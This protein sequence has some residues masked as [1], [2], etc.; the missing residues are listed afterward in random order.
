MKAD[1]K[2]LESCGCCEGIDTL[3]PESIQNPPGLSAIAYRVGTHSSFKET[4]KAKLAGDAA[5]SRLATRDDDD[6]TIALLDAWA[7]VAD[8]LTFY[9]ERIANEGYLRTAAERRSVLELARSLGYELKPGV[10]ASTYLAFELETAP[11]S[12]GFATIDVGTKVQSLPGPGEKPQTFET[13]EKIEARSALNALKPKLT[14]LRFPARGDQSLYLA[15]ISTNLKPGDPLLIVGQERETNEH[16]PQWELRRVAGVEPDAQANRTLIRLDK[17]LS[18]IPSVEPSEKGPRVCALRTRAALFG[19]NAQ[20]WK[21][22]PAALRDNTDA[23]YKDRENDWADHPFS[24][25]TTTI[26]LDAVYTQVV[27]NSWIVLASPTHEELYRVTGVGEETKA[28]FNITGKTTRLEIS[29]EN[30]DEFSARNATVYAQSEEL[31]MAEAP[32]VKPVSG[33]EIVLD[34]VVEGLERGQQLLVTGR[35]VRAPLRRAPTLEA[36]EGGTRTE[37]GSSLKGIPIPDLTG[38]R[39]LP[40]VVD[41]K[42]TTEVVE[43]REA[44]PEGDRY[45]TL[46]LAEPLR[47]AYD[48]PSV[49]IHGNVAAATH[50]ETRREVL[51]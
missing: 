17:R 14:R 5:L 16:S 21:A 27:L 30:I 50:G 15:G 29:G 38:V 31:K 46:I 19:H 6:P 18:R 7:S 41:G 32:I 48:R 51:G 43:L 33:Q 35:R 20:E 34:R 44:V 39:L 49:T 12:P 45:T 9:Q 22:L 10:A 37:L 1:D 13:I 11:G 23:A 47:N 3:T 26:N 42:T 24:E 25:R 40:P 8:V 36:V 4:M 2:T 28:D